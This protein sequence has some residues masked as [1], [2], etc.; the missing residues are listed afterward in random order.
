MFG[1][2]ENASMHLDAI[3][4]QSPLMAHNMGIEFVSNCPSD[5]VSDLDR[6]GRYQQRGEK[7]PFLAEKKIVSKVNVFNCL[8]SGADVFIIPQSA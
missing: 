1:A 4:L 3:E 8:R 2:I 6:I 7:S 5:T